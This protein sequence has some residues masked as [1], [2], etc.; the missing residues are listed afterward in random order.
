VQYG[1]VR[2]E[3]IRYR[4][5]IIIIIVIISL[6]CWGRVHTHLKFILLGLC[7]SCIFFVSVQ[8][9]INLCLCW[10][11][12]WSCALSLHVNKRNWIEVNWT[13]L[14]YQYIQEQS[15][16]LN[17]FLLQQFQYNSCCLLL[18]VLCC[19]YLFSMC[20]CL[21]VVSWCVCLMFL[22]FLCNWLY[23]RSAAHDW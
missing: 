2:D 22:C 18:G 7:L 19:S 16:S 11:C 20:L 17:Y 12:N 10:F 1:P 21:W 3:K 6:F 8:L 14:C 9:C 4:I 23:G 5:I 15:I 13:L